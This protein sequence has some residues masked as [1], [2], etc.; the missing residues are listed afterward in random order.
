M[1]RS[2]SI[3]VEAARSFSLP[4]MAAESAKTVVNNIDEAADARRNSK[5][6]ASQWIKLNVG[7]TTFMTTRTTLCK[8]H[9]SFLYRLVQEEPDL[10]TD[11]VIHDSMLF[12]FYCL[13]TLS[14]RM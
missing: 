8:D 9:K 10:N 7:G 13:F 3:A 5:S 2:T 4:R 12:K 6:R 1:L 11:K 14:V